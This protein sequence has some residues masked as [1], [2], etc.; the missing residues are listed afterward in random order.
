MSGSKVALLLMKKYQDIADA[1]WVR[2]LSNK[3]A[4][5]IAA[6]VFFIRKNLPMLAVVMLC[7]NVAFA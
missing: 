2:K 1:V 7:V 3:I 6:V 5:G 4:S